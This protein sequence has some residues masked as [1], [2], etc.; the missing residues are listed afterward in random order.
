MPITQYK[1][2]VLMTDN[3]NFLTLCEGIDATLI[4]TRTCKVPMLS[5]LETPFSFTQ[6]YP[7]KVR[8]TAANALGS[9]TESFTS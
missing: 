6:G 4:S 9:G 1:V 5:L 8:V 3:T 2:E 7:I